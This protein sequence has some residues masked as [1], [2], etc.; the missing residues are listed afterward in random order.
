MMARLPEIVHRDRFSCVNV[1]TAASRALAH[2]RRCRLLPIVDLPCLLAL[3]IVSQLRMPS[4][5][6]DMYNVKLY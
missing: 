2:C 5:A 6:Q 4:C 3:E 1:L